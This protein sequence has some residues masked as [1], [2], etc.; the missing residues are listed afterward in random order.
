MRTYTLPGLVLTDHTFHVPLDH[1]QPEGE[2]ITVYAREVVAPQKRHESLPWLVF[3]QGGPGGKSPRPMDANGWIGRAVQ[4]FRVLLLDQRGTGRSTPANHQSLALRGDA[5]AQAAYLMHFRADAIVRDAEYIRARLLAPGERW[6]VLGQSYGGFCILNYLSSA[7]EALREA[8]ITGGLPSVD[9]S[10]DDVYRHTYRRVLDKNRRYFERYPDDQTQVHAIAMHLQANDVRLPN[11]E[12]LSPRRLQWLGL[13]FG[14]SDGFEAVHYLIEEAFI[15]TVEGETL[16]DTFLYGVMNLATL[17]TNPLFAVIHEPIYA[18]GV[19]S[20]WAAERIRA[21]YPQFE[22]TPDQPFLFTGEMIYPWMFDED[23]A[24]QPLK[25][26]AERLAHHDNWPRLYAAERLRTNTVP[27]A[28][29]VY[30][31]DMYVERTLSEETARLIPECRIWL[32]NE[33][34]HNGLRADGDRILGRLIAM[35]RGEV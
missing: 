16:S 9:A 10:A 6:S 21:E 19:G 22:V 20:H 3:F 15:T 24:L 11:G 5:A 29:A 27:C 34:E 33:Y 2:Q 25:E 35:T 18:Q 32:T 4:E 23:R 14:M 30:A 12:R 1:A 26:V 7:P 28:A 31:D 17:A 13:G 8:F